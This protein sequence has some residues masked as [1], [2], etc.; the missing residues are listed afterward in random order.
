[1]ENETSGRIRQGLLK[2][3]EKEAVTSRFME[4]YQS[5]LAIEAKAENLLGNPSSDLREDIIKERLVKGLPLLTFNELD[6]NWMMADDIF[7]EVFGAFADYSDIFEVLALKSD[8]TTSLPHLS[9]EAAQ[10]WFEG[11]KLNNTMAMHGI[12]ENSMGFLIQETLSPFLIRHAQVLSDSVKQEKWRRAY[13]PVCG[14]MP[15]FA[16]LDR[17]VGARWLMC[18]RCNTEWLFQRLQC[19]YCGNRNHTSLSFLTD[20][21]G[22]YRLYICDDCHTYLKAIDLRKTNEDIFIP[23][24]RLITFNMDHEGQKRRYKAAVQACVNKN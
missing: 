10:A 7:T 20:S 23:L 19:P 24:E 4:F 6:I 18:A 9:K 2:W 14:G 1:M 3:C 21:A 13:C 15:D 17:N 8:S 5:I 16:F 11:N 22:L 12:T